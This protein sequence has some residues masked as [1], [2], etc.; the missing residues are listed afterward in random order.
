MSKRSNIKLEGTVMST[1]STNVF[2]SL[3]DKYDYSECGLCFVS[4]QAE[5]VVEHRVPVGTPEETI[6]TYNKVV[7]MVELTEVERLKI[8]KG[9]LKRIIRSNQYES[10]QLYFLIVALMALRD[11]SSFVS[12]CVIATMALTHVDFGFIINLI[13]SKFTSEEEFEALRSKAAELNLMDYINGCE[14]KD[15]VSLYCTMLDGTFKSK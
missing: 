3:T 10:I 6:T 5:N 15:D 14:N 1:R 2:K 11:K 7:Q 13:K 8:S 9:L 4:K 12:W